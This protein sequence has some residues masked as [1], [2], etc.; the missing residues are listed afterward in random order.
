MIKNILS[1]VFLVSL[2]APSVLAQSDGHIHFSNRDNPSSKRT[3]NKEF[4]KFE[5]LNLDT[6]IS[7]NSSSTFTLD[8][9]IG[10]ANYIIEAKAN[11][12]LSP[13]YSAQELTDEG[14]KE[15]PPPNVRTFK[16]LLSGLPLSSTRFS[17]VGSDLQV[18]M[19]NDGVRTLYIEPLNRFIKGANPKYYVKYYSTDVKRRNGRCAASATNGINSVETSGERGACK[20]LEIA[21]VSDYSMRQEYGNSN[22]VNNYIISILNLSEDDFLVFDIEFQI[23]SQVVS[24]SSSNDPVSSNT[25]AYVLL[26]EFNIWAVSNITGSHDVGQFWTQRD[27]DGAVI[28]IADAP[29]IFSNQ[30]ICAT[31]RYS[32]IGDYS[33]NIQLMRNLVTHETGHNFDAQ[34]DLQGSSYIMAPSNGNY[35][36][37]ST[38]SINQINNYINNINCLSPCGN[39]VSG[40]DCSQAIP[41]QSYT[42]CSYTSST[43]TGA[44][45]SGFPI[46]NC[47]TWVSPTA[48]DVWFSFQ[49]VSTTH[50]I[51]VDPQGT[52][53]G[54]SDNN[55]VDPVIVIYNSCS[56][57]AIIQCED[58][59]G[60]GGGNCDMIV[61]NLVIGNTYYVRVYDYGSS[62]PM[63]GGFDVCVTHSGGATSCSTPSNPDEDA[64]GADYVDFDWSSVSNAFQYEL[65]YRQVGGNWQTV[66][67][68]SSSATVNGLACNSDYEWQVR[69]VCSN[70]NSNYTSIKLL[71]TDACSNNCSHVPHDLE[72]DFVDDDEVDLDWIGF[73]SA[74]GYELRYREVGSGWIT[75][76]PTVSSYDLDF[77]T[78]GT[79]YEWQV[80]TIC[81]NGN[82]GNFSSIESFSTDNCSTVPCSIPPD[83]ATDYIEETM[84]YFIWDDAP[85]AN[86]YE[87]R[88]RKSGGSWNTHY[89]IGVIHA[90]FSLTCGTSYEWQIRSDCGNSNYSAWSSLLTFTTKPCPCYAPN[91]P[92]LV[93]PPNGSYQANNITLEWNQDNC[94]DYYYFEISEANDQFFSNGPGFDT[95]YYPLNS[96]ALQASGNIPNYTYFYWRVGGYNSN[97][98]SGLSPTYWFIY[99]PVFASSETLQTIHSISVYPNPNAGIFNVSVSMN[100]P[101][102]IS[103]ELYDVLGQL[104]FKDKKGQ[105]SGSQVFTIDHRDCSKGIYFLKI[106]T[107]SGEIV[108]KLSIK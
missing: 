56:S 57:N 74:M 40:D 77:L 91:T 98:Y 44:T 35:S 31:Y 79:T 104:V 92:S 68:T 34:H 85:N 39:V 4:R 71:T 12:L 25:D 106:V 26:D 66:V 36:S 20:T 32:L 102:D 46:P 76:S 48:L 75:L 43:V 10:N 107:P 103:L 55:Y 8:V 11:N 16:G 90:E 96:I 22:S 50:T 14:R 18:L 28:G 15:I 97:G 37:W 47:N 54:T 84:A 65:R 82:I 21:T 61:S 52:Y 100:V 93:S 38:N 67:V 80:A 42:S 30:G 41:L 5:I 60:G 89:Q 1:L 7:P 101:A 2:L 78:C 62:Q 95:M 108:E 49:A 24:S 58:D 53:T 23:T 13:N 59:N 69:A 51:T 9:K 27:F 45:Y 81:A 99:H 64:I 19:M 3:L 29:F 87:L 63:Y 73:S 86:G 70:G 105:V 17:F 72:V 83:L 94:I 88:W 6:I 33:T